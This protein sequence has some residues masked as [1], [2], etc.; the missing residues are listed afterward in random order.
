[1]FADAEGFRVWGGFGRARCKVSG[2]YAGFAFGGGDELGHGGRLAWQG[3]FEQLLIL[4]GQT[5]CR[6]IFSSAARSFSMG[7]AQYVAIV[8][9]RPLA[10]NKCTVSGPSLQD[11]VR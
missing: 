1:M 3:E 5:R 8:C 7:P 4:A 2:L 9:S 6:P 10:S 11:D